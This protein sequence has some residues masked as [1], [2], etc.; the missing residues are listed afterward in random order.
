VLVFNKIDA[1]ETE[2]RPLHLTDSFDLDGVSIPRVFVSARSG[3]GLPELRAQLA[4]IVC[5]AMPGQAAPDY[6]SHFDDATP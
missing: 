4:A 1:L 3:E 5:Q 2:R 6:A